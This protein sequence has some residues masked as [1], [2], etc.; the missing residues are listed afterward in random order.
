MDGFQV[1]LVVTPALLLSP[2]VFQRLGK[3]RYMERSEISLTESR[4]DF[5]PRK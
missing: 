4:W 2:I 1:S 5:P 3:I